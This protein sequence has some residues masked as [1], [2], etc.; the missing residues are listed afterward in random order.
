ML[1]KV[2]VIFVTMVALS[3]LVGC[4]CSSSKEA[5]GLSSSSTT[6][7]ITT[8]AN[9]DNEGKTE[10]NTAANADATIND[11]ENNSESVSDTET[12][13]KVNETKE[14]EATKESQ[15]AE[16]SQTTKQQQVS[17][18]TQTTKKQ[19]STKETQ[20]TKKQQTTKATQTT[21]KQQTTKVPETTKEQETTTKQNDTPAVKESGVIYD[22]LTIQYV[23]RSPYTIPNTYEQ[24]MSDYVANAGTYDEEDV[25]PDGVIM[26]DCSAGLWSSDKVEDKVFGNEL[27]LSYGEDIDSVKLIK[28][29]YG[30]PLC[31]TDFDGVGMFDYIVYKYK[32]NKANNEYEIFIYFQ[33]MKKE[34]VGVS[35]KIGT[36]EMV[37]EDIDKR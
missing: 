25:S 20:T 11:T 24:L 34:L 14:T 21:K 13:K 8:K 33:M 17:K 37:R 19:Q 4:S 26:V 30:E 29:L 6:Q 10:A 15:K 35:Y 16:E 31:E 9:V 22:T 23:N 32:T 36:E 28:E 1:K 3:V 2:K 5:N 27:R 18:E 12:T 7:E